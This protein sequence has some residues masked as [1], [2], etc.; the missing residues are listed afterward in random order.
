VIQARTLKRTGKKVYD[1]RLRDPAGRVYNRTFPTKKAAEAFEDSERT[2]RRRDEWIDP[3]NSSIVVAELASRWMESNPAKRSSTRARDEAIL[4]RH[5]LP[6]LGGRRI[7]SV[8]QPDVQGLVNMWAA[9]AAPRTV[10]RQYDVLHALFAYAVNA[11]YRAKSPCRDIRLPEAKPLRRKLPDPDQLAALAGELDPTSALMMWVSV[12]T[13]LR[14]GEVAGLRVASIDL[15]RAE[16]RVVEQRTRD[17]AGDDVTALPKSDAGIRRL[18]L[19][20]T[21][22]AM[23]SEHLGRRGVTGADGDALVF[24]ELLA[25]AAAALEAGV[26]PG[27]RAGAHIPRSPAL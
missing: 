16:L 18:R 13:G 27:R 7:G 12:L 9:T 25:L 1:V 22:V 14:W 24:V 4:R 5:I 21:L 20:S 3:R 26:P 17:L 6:V 10:D 23:I 15:L 2:D 8:T 19:P 11:E